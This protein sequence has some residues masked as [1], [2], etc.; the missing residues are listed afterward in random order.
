M[1]LEMGLELNFG[2]GGLK[3]VKR[4]VGLGMTGDRLVNET[5]YVEGL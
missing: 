3:R 1:G 4:M 5:E 2:A